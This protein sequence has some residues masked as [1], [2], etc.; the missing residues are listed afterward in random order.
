MANKVNLMVKLGLTVKFDGQIEEFDGQTGTDEFDGQTGT[1][2][3]DVQTETSPWEQV[4][5]PRNQ[6]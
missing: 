1:D 3:F 5:F 6:S 2:E 4:N